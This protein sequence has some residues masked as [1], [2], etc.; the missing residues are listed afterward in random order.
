[1]LYLFFIK[2]S[3]RNVIVGASTLTAGNIKKGVKIFNVTGTFTGWVDSTA[4]IYQSGSASTLVPWITYTDSG[5]SVSVTSSWIQLYSA[6]N[7]RNHD[8]AIVFDLNNFINKTAWMYITFSVVS[9]YGG[10]GNI[11][12]VWQAYSTNF[13]DI[14]I[15]SGF[16]RTSHTASSTVSNDYVVGTYTRCDK[17]VLNDKPL[18]C[19]GPSMRNLK[20]GNTFSVR[21]T[22]IWLQFV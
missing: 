19:I 7:S 12:S 2:N 15:S 8:A 1:M 9:N 11:V 22:K 5:M 4:I 6:S 17:V 3:N 13:S 18:R 16:N 20:T 21:F 10:S 14:M